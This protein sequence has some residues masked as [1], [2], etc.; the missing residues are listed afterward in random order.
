MVRCLSLCLAALAGSVPASAQTALGPVFCKT[1][2]AAGKYWISLPATGPVRSAEELKALIPNAVEVKKLFPVST[3]YTLGGSCTSQ[4]PGT[5]VPLTGCAT[6]ANPLPCFCVRPGEAFQ[7]EV[8]A[9]AV[10]QILG[11][12]T[13]PTIP[14]SPGG[15]LYLIS[16]PFSTPILTAR[17]LMNDI[18]FANVNAVSR[19]ISATDGME[20]YTGRK[21]SPNVDFVIE[22]GRGYVVN[23]NTAVTYT[24][25]ISPPV[26][27]ACP[28]SESWYGITGTAN[29]TDFPW[30]IQ[31]GGATTVCANAAGALTNLGDPPTMAANF[32]NDINNGPNTPLC[33]G[34]AIA[35][36]TA[37][38]PIFKVTFTGPP[39]A[40]ALLVGFQGQGVSCNVNTAGSCDFNPTISRLEPPLLSPERLSV[41]RSGA[42]NLLSWN[43]NGD[44]TLTYNVYRDTQPNPAFWP[45]PIA[46]GVV[47]AA[48]AIPGIQFLDLGAF[49][50]T[51]S[52]YYKVTAVNDVAESP[53]NGD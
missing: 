46:V 27:S 13:S 44:A 34:A 12:D 19:Y 36:Q 45:P 14:L 1:L 22:A 3:P 18:G 43:D 7:V 33:T 17:A 28:G 2:P 26:I 6:N 9:P 35:T 30:E 10:F 15:A 25:S 50:T 37:G 52:Y 24:P 40:P 23:M 48:P 38:S 47:D 4:E 41:S 5:A 49:A 39:G 29:T 32:A 11:V 8:I 42:D 51:D 20:I 53:L 16:L 21:G 31:D